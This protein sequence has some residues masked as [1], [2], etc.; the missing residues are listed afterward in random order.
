MRNR[1]HRLARNVREGDRHDLIG[2]AGGFERETQAACPPHPERV[3][4]A[5]ASQTHVG[6]AGEHEHLIGRCSVRGAPRRQED[7]VGFLAVRD[8]RRLLGDANARAVRFD[9]TDAAAQ[10]ASNSA[11]GGRRRDEPL[12]LRELGEVVPEVRRGEP[13]AH[14]A[15]DLDLVHRVDHGR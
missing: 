5:G 10:V 1:K 11:L 4:F 12:V 3:P 9:R 7:V 2:A 13:V 15:S 14:Q 8:D 6:L